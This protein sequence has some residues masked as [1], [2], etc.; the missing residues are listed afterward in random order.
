MRMTFGRGFDSRLWG[1]SIGGSSRAIMKYLHLEHY[2]SH[3]IAK[4]LGGVVRLRPSFLA[5]K[6]KNAGRPVGC[7]WASF[8]LEGIVGT[9][10]VG[11]VGA[12]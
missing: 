2:F 4:K 10:L 9:A 1:R 6:S 3:C 12:V 5:L 7:V 8:I 11:A